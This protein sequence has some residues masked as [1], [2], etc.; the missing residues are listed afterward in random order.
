M[1]P[2]MSGFE[3]GQSP[4]VIHQIRITSTKLVMYWSSPGEV[5]GFCPS[6]YRVRP[7]PD[8]Q[9]ST[10]PGDRVTP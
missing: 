1:S 3:L 4:L 2:I 8:H 6:T 10:H 9:S 5:G 7:M